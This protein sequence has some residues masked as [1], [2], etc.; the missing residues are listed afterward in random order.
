MVENFNVQQMC[1][2]IHVLIINLHYGTII[3]A[4]IK[5]LKPSTRDLNEF[6]DSDCMTTI[7][8]WKSSHV[9]VWIVLCLFRVIFSA[10]D[11]P[12]SSHVSA[13]SLLWMRLCLFS[14]SYSSYALLQNEHLKA[15]LSSCSYRM[16]EEYNRRESNTAEQWQQVYMSEIPWTSCMCSFSSLCQTFS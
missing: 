5:L 12:H 9:P 4:T 15:F 16:W 1:F 11:L 6:Y 2:C 13:S 8:S 7:N 3:S 10:N 14:D